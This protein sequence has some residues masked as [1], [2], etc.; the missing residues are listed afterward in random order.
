MFEC[1]SLGSSSS[2]PS[3]V[4]FNSQKVGQVRVQMTRGN[5][6]HLRAYAAAS[7]DEPQDGESCS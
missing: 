5:G 1:I 2:F 3:A 4:I 6:K 7:D